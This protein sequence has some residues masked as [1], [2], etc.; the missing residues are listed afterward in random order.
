MEIA[1]TTYAF[2]SE[3]RPRVWLSDQQP[4]DG[5]E[6]FAFS[7][8]SLFSRTV[9]FESSQF[10][11]FEWRYASKKEKNRFS[12]SPPDTLLLLERIGDEEEVMVAIFVRSKETSTVGSKG[13]CAG[14]VVLL[15]IMPGRKEVRM[16]WLFWLL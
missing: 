15:E 9:A 4:I 1:R 7:S 12:S 5:G 6:E 14:N 8:K 10:W 16:D 11:K 2:G 13:T 3:R